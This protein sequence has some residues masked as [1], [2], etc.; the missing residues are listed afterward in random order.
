MGGGLVELDTCI[1]DETHSLLL[2]TYMRHAWI[3]R[4]IFLLKHF[5]GIYQDSS[6]IPRADLTFIKKAYTN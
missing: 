3:I 4:I 1:C 5:F 2:I 6:A